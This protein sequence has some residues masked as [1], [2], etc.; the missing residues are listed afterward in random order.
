M[1][2]LKTL[3]AAFIISGFGLYGMMGARTISNRVKQ[4]RNIR[5]AM[6]FLEKEISYL[7][8]PLP[9]A[10]ERAAQCTAE[11]ARTLF[12]QCGHIL[13]DKQ[14]MTIPEAWTYSLEKLRSVS[15]LKDEDLE[16]LKVL[17]LQ[18]GVSG[19]DEQKKLFKMIQ[20]QLKLQEE[21]ARQGVEAECKIR[22]YGGFILGTTVV[23]LLL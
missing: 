16:V 19:L 8:T 6:G 17:S 22:A 20:E 12:Y 23:I 5:I 15:N 21:K 9:L 13:Q 4:I 3:G 11:P 7:H 18:M 10:M 14:G 2:W 1:L